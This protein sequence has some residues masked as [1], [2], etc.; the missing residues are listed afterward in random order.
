MNAEQFLEWRKAFVKDSLSNTPKQALVM[1]ILNVT[2]DSFYDCGRYKSTDQALKRALLM[3]EQGADLIDVGGESTRPY[4]TK[5]S[6]DEEL[7][8]VIPLIDKLRSESDIAISIDTYKSEVMRL[9]VAAGANFINDVCALRGEGSLDVALS[10]NVPIC[11]M[12][13]QGDPSTMQKA[14][15]YA[16]GVVN[17]INQ[18]FTER[19][20]AC[21]EKGIPTSQL[22]LDPGFGFGKSV[23]DNLL[24]VNAIQTFKQHNLPILLG[25]SRKSTITAILGQSEE[26]SLIGS[27]TTAIIAVQNGASI[28]RTHD[29]LETKQALKMLYFARAQ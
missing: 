28:I 24:V 1:G 14:P 21:V 9:A 23:Q 2:P 18:F 17:E 5:V 20:R 25:A 29:V 3:I 10:A 7:D 27:I 16:L 22:I 4:A 19:I 6:L 12:H 13:M 15:H 11:L 26:A 8:R